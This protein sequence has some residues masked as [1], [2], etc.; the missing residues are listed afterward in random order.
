MNKSLYFNKGAWLSNVLP[1]IPTNIVLNKTITG[2]G[3]TTL[4]ITTPRH[5]IIIEP[6]VPVIQGK[7]KA[8]KNVFPVYEEVS[9]QQV[10]EYLTKPAECWRKIMTTPEGY[11]K[12]LRLALAEL[13]PDY[14]EEFFMLF[15]ECEKIIQDVDYRGDICLPVDDFFQFKGKAMVSATPIMPSDPRFV[16]QN[17][18]LW[19]IVPTYDYKQ[20][21]N[22][23]VTNNTMAVLGEIVKLAT[24]RSHR[25]CVFIN[26]TDTIHRAV[27]TLQLTDRCK[28]F[29]GEKSVKKLKERGFNSAYC[30]LQEEL[31]EVNFFTSR[32]YSAVDIVLPYRPCVVI[33]SDVVRAPF[34]A[35]DPATELIQAVGRFRKGVKGVWHVTNTNPRRL[36][37]TRE[38]MLAHLTSQERFYNKVLSIEPQ[39]FAER[40][41]KERAL[42]AMEYHRFVTSAG[43][44][45]YF[46]WDNALDFEKIKSY[47]LG[48]NR[49]LKA[50]ET[51]PVQL[52]SVKKKELILSD[53]DRIAREAEQIS[54]VKRWEIVTGQIKRLYANGTH[55]ED[56]IVAELEGQFR[57]IV[58]AYFVIG[59]AEIEALRYNERKILD[60][61]QKLEVAKQLACANIRAEI[62]GRFKEGDTEP[63]EVVNNFM[64]EIIEKHHI[65]LSGRIDRRYIS[66]YFEIE[67]C[68]QNGARA[69]RFVR[70]KW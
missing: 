10:R 45:N 13:K 46:M 43:N 58:H 69:F 28:V 54:N 66:L 36:C 5:S 59:L 3:A 39:D 2:C 64:A 48:L 12:K 51:A 53:E 60:R 68:K 19:K 44:R 70:K 50:Y 38:Y 55:S 21:V 47:Y 65:E 11:D 9:H 52:S 62:Y 63:V 7:V 31:A 8:H 14:H 32:F 17:F 27:N 15:D 29:C 16:E 22:L 24:E 41:E 4:E 33:L 40:D 61:V 18:E 20:K 56:A 35:I 42:K 23:I 37:I 26:S 34:S 25:V 49:L 67:D 57:Q 30:N 6:N 1:E